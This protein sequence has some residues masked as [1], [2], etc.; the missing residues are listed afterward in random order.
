[1]RRVSA[2]ARAILA[3]ELLVALA[4][5]PSRSPATDA[6]GSGGPTLQAR[7]SAPASSHE[8]AEVRDA[9]RRDPGPPSPPAS[10]R[11]NGSCRAPGSF[12]QAPARTN[13]RVELDAGR[14]G[15]SLTVHPRDPVR[16]DVFEGRVGHHRGPGRRTRGAPTG[17]RSSF[18]SRSS[19]RDERRA[20]IRDT[21]RGRYW[22]KRPVTGG[23]SRPPPPQGEELERLR[24][25]AP[26][27]ARA[28]P[29]PSRT[30]SAGRPRSNSPFSSGG[31]SSRGRGRRVCVIRRGARV[32]VGPRRSTDGRGCEIRPPR[33]SSRRHHSSAL[34]LGDSVASSA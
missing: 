14:P 24:R 7:S 13:R 8:Y 4:C 22:R 31:N 32:R 29:V 21:H 11:S 12:A 2:R 26:S 23:S 17:L 15:L 3:A 18:G 1:V 19:D 27:P 16:A 20:R 9:C 5:G 25:S 28:P 33:P 34:I 6:S 30:H 10:D